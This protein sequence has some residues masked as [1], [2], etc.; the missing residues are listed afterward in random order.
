MSTT[1]SDLESFTHS[2]GYGI[3]IPKPRRRADPRERS[4]CTPSVGAKPFSTLDP[5][6]GGVAK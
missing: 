5:G 2:L 3:R 6:G 1:F 4:H